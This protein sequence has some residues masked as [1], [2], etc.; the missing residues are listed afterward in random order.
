MHR[1]LF[2]YVMTNNFILVTSYYKYDSITFILQIVLK[3][4][5]RCEN[6][7]LFYGFDYVYIVYNNNTVCV[8]RSDYC[9]R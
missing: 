2:Q 8:M 3:I 7:R 5:N 9:V 4:K 6:A 1:A